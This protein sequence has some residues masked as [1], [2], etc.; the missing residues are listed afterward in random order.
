MAG[1]IDEQQMSA[2]DVFVGEWGMTAS[3]APGTAVE[4]RARTVFEWLKG[5]RLLVQRWEVDHPDAPD[6]VAII[7]PARPRET[8]SS[9]TST[10]GVSSAPT[11]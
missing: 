1:T 11:R 10:R 3:F 9:I 6:G 5:R 2:L 7:G 4:P 8:T